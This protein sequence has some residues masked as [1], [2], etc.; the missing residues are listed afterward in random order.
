MTPV[1]SQNGDSLPKNRLL[2]GGAI[3]ILGELARLGVPFVVGSGLP[4]GWKNFLS[5]LL[6]F[7]IPEGGMLV[8]IVILGK[9]GFNYLR[10]LVFAKIRRYALP[11]TV[12]RTRY[13]LGLVLFLLPLFYSWLSPYLP[14]LLHGYE[15][16]RFVAFV[17]DLILL[18][19]L[20]LLGGDFWDK[21]R[22][23]FV[24]KAKV[25]FPVGTRNPERTE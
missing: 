4:I 21:L 13:R 17:G 15:T 14:L 11:Q 3:F 7:A 8:S 18:V 23:L 24:Y 10:G 20:L 12:S 1:K 6:L 19:S 22:A 9:P 5:A 25:Q 16:T 2:V